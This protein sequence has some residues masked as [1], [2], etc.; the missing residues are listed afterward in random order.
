MDRGLDR[1]TGILETAVL[2]EILD[3]GLQIVDPREKSVERLLPDA[4]ALLEKKPPL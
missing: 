3:L 4:V 2:P 1:A